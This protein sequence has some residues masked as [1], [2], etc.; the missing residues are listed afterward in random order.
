[1]EDI[2]TNKL[3]LRRLKKLHL[4]VYCSTIVVL[5]DAQELQYVDGG[6]YHVDPRGPAT[7]PTRHP[8]DRNL[9]ETETWAQLVD[10]LLLVRRC[11]LTQCVTFDLITTK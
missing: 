6:R 1:M 3:Y 10:L 8:C 4:K 5:V 9:G 7:C 2:S 11:L